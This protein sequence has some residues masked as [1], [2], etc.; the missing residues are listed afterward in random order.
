[1]P[2]RV[3]DLVTA[4]GSGD[5]VTSVRGDKVQVQFPDRPA[6]QFWFPSADV[7]VGAPRP[8]PV[9]MAR[10]YGKKETR[11]E[12]RAVCKHVNIAALCPECKGD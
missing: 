3:G 12:V 1:M 7:L 8:R 5:R 6:F 2:I 4:G 11:V 10:R 9:M